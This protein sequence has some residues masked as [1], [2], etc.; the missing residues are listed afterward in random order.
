MEWVNFETPFFSSEKARR[1][2]H[3]TG[4]P[5]TVKRI[6]ETY[7]D[8]LKNPHCGYGG[9]MN[10]CLDCHALMFRL[11]GD[12]MREKGF[13]FLFSGEVVGQRPM[14]QTKPSLRYVEKNSGHDGYIVRPL[15]ARLLP[16]SRPEQEGLVDRDRLLDISGRGR[17]DQIRMAREFGISDYPAP[18]GGCL[19]TDVGF[20]RRLRDLLT[21]V[22]HPVERD[23][24]LLKYG[25]HFRLPDGNKVIVGRTQKDNR[26]ILG[27]V[28]PHRDTTLRMVGMPSPTVLIPGGAVKELIDV[29]AGLCGAYSKAKEGSVTTVSAKTPHGTRQFRITV[30][31]RGPFQDLAV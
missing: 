9:N 15:S 1:A 6:T 5:L 25:R 29:A 21:H 24:E 18:A 7:M 13:Q 11:A 26:E 12:I 17:K 28:D 8:M 30:P 2:A 20:S 19:L 23:L 3:M 31:A 10:P 4:I 27:L 22:A 14:S 16:P